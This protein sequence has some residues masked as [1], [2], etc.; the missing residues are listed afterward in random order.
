MVT[1]AVRASARVADAHDL[2]VHQLRDVDELLHLFQL[3]ERTFPPL[4]TV[5]NTPRSNLPVRPTRLI[6]RDAEVAL[7][8]QHLATH[9]LVTITAVGGS[10][11][12]RLAIA[13]GEDELD[14]R[15]DGVWFVDLTPVMNDLDVPAAIAAAIGLTLGPGSAQNQ[16]LEY[17]AGK[18]ALVILDNCEHLVDAVAD[19]VEQFLARAGDSV[20]LATSREAL[21]IDGEQLVHLASLATTDGDSPAVRLFTER[22]TAV[23]PR[24]AL[25]ETNTSTIAIDL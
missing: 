24:F 10:G 25:D 19:F 9:R 14:H 20:I 11:K 2:G 16:V 8:R 18:A 1:E 22:A 4:R 6:G 7:V 23:E 15:K 12:T 17:L 13:V 3:G 5:S 21:D